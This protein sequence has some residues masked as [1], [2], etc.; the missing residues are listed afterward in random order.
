MEGGG[1]DDGGH[2]VVG[3]EKRGDEKGDEGVVG[4]E[5]WEA[6]LECLEPLDEG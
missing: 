4:C 2:C 6:C 1:Q 5:C 3:V